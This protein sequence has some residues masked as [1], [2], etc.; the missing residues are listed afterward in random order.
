MLGIDQEVTSVCVHALDCFKNLIGSAVLLVQLVL[1]KKRLGI[2]LTAVPFSR[3][4]DG[5]EGCIGILLVLFLRNLAGI[6]SMDCKDTALET[7][8]CRVLV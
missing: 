8:T 1:D 6:G 3:N 7:T 2:P 4:L 5:I